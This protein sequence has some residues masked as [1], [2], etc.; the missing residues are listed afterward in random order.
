MN[1]R[2][3]ATN[4]EEVEEALKQYNNFHDDYIAGIEIKF[5]NYKGL[6]ADGRSTGIGNADKTIILTVNTY[7]YGKDHEQFVNVELK[8]VKSF[9]ISS[10]PEDNGANPG[11]DWGIFD[12]TILP[13]KPERNDFNC[14]INFVY[15][16]SKF[17]VIC[18][19]IVF[20]KQVS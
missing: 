3:E 4:F 14:E 7:P 16:D 2:F 9:E 5:E 8:D 20:H 17:I 6:D 15:G 10:L 11:P 19:K 13:D 1:D 12:M 18:S